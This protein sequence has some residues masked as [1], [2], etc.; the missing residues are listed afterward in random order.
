MTHAADLF[1]SHE[2]GAL[3]HLD[4]LLHAGEGH[5]EGVGELADGGVATAEALENAAARGVGH[6]REGIVEGGE[7]G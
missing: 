6:G 3:E 2:V 5:A 7:R 1:G 4:V